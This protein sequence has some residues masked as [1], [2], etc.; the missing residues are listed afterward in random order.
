M[1]RKI[2]L[3]VSGLNAS[4][5]I[6]KS[7]RAITKMT[8]NASFPNPTP[9]LADLTTATEELV[10]ATQVAAGGDR[11]AILIRD[12]KKQNVA[13]MLRIL[14]SYVTVAADGDGPI[15]AS[16]GFDLQ[17]LPEPQPTITRPVD[18]VS[19]RGKHVGEVNVTWQSVKGARLYIVEMTNADPSDPQAVWKEERT[20]A[21]AKA[22]FM[23]TQIGSFFSYPV[24]AIGRNSE[25]PWSDI[26]V[27]MTAA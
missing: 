6:T 13:N 24:K 18:F 4:K 22:N 2:K 1:R 15:L 14:G 25:S 10:Q 12:Q 23:Y 9:S 17:N 11:Q 27:V 26:S 3:E 8:G 19:E 21:Q 7:F 20:T 16:S 5:L